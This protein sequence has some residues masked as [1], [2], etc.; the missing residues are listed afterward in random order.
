[1]RKTFRTP[2]LGAALVALA[3]IAA[4]CNGS[5]E[6][7]DGDGASRGQITV[8]AVAFAENQILGEMY[9]Q[10]LEDAGYE[11]S[12]QLS[13]DSREILQP[14]MESGEVDVAPEYLATLSAFLGGETSSDPDE[15]VEILEPLLEEQGQTVLDYSE[16]IDTNAFVVTRETAE[17]FNLSA[18]S[19]L[20]GVAGDM[21][22]G[23][24]PECPEREFCI[25]GLRD[26]YGVEFGQ[27]VPLDVG[28][29]LTVEALSNGEIDVG[30]LFSTDG[31]IPA[32][33]FVLLEDDMSLQQA[34]N[35][36]PV[37]R[38]EVLD[39]EIRTILD[40]ISAALTT[41]K[42]TALNAQV[43]VEGGDPA[44]AARTFLDEEGII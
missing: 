17:Q 14:A 26:V 8:G 33:D 2:V 20:Q 5:G 10:A 21:T 9:A 34:D 31:A 7:G 37:V 16:A 35:I 15:Q 29:P 19:D 28:G 43:T 11:V 38:T 6:G 23:G 22:L 1:M 24:P 12:R 36:A 13:L 41:E 25:P 18:V 27:F 32:N 44:E 30:L 39:E 42:M 3:L 4:A 40:A